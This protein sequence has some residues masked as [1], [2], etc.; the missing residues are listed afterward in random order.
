MDEIPE[1]GELQPNPIPPLERGLWTTEFW[2]HMLS[3]L[4]VILAVVGVLTTTQADSV[5]KAIAAVVAAATSIFGASK[6]STNR[7][8]LKSLEK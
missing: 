3:Q 8:E 2:L 4:I 1:K 6:Y 5:T 7:T